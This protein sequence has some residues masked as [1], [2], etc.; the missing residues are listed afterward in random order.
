VNSLKATNALEALTG[1][2]T[3]KYSTSE[4][5]LD[6]VQEFMEYG[7]CMTGNTSEGD[8]GVPSKVHRFE[9]QTFLIYKL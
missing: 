8:N 6:G 4:A 1:R 7:I 2:K 9:I 3:Q 5:T